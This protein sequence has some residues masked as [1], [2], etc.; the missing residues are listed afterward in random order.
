MATKYDWVVES[1]DEWED[2]EDVNF[3]ETYE[4]TQQELYKL[5]S[6]RVGL[7]KSKSNKEL[8]SVESRVYAYICDGVLDNVFDDGSKVPQRYIKQKD[9]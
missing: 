6:Y 5:E 2:I 4:E 3:Y 1:L 7:C 9:N 8:D